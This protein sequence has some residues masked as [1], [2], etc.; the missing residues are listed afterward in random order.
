MGERGGCMGNQ[1]VRYN[2]MRGAY[3]RPSRVTSTTK[4]E[5]AK[6]PVLDSR[7]WSFVL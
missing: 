1:Y 6:H 5:A 3:G 7:L 2:E 4:A